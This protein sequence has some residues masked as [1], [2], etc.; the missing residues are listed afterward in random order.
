MGLGNDYN[1]IKNKQAG[2]YQ[3]KGFC[4]AKETINKVK[5]QPME[6]EKIFVNHI[7]DK[8]VNIQNI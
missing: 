2:L 5:R 1:K 4:T 7:S 8:R 3:R 6:W